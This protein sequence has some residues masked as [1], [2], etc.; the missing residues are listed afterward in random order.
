MLLATD[1][2]PDNSYVGQKSELTPSSKAPLKHYQAATGNIKLFFI[3]KD[4]YTSIF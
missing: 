2:Y 1:H 4:N 3:S